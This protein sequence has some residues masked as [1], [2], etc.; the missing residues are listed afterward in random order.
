VS[1][2]ITALF[3]N[4]PYREGEFTGLRS[5]RG[6]IWTDVD[7][8]RTGLPEWIFADDFSYARYVD[9]ALD[10][11]MFF[12]KRQGH[13]HPHHVPF[14]HFLEQGFETP[15]GARH[16]PRRADWE[17]HLST[18]FPEAR[19]KPFIEVR[20]PDAVGSRLVCALP[21]V[22]KGILYDDQSAEAAWELVGGLDHPARLELWREARVHA[23]NSDRVHELA[24]KLLRYSREGLERLDVRDSK[25][26]TEAR[27]LDPL[28][29][30]VGRRASLAQEAIDALGEHPGTDR[31][32]RLAFLRHYHFA[33]AGGPDEA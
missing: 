6:E 20:S 28:D 18:L 32:A 16:F 12:V 9:Y 1:S 21:A 4:A 10:I 15:D 8:D 5:L 19:L 25:G 29:E 24:G 31:E 22:L 26:R 13:Y 14:R 17:L 11:P 33:G 27:F 7:P 30:M 3:A 23:L 2:I